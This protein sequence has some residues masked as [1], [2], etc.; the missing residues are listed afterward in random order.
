M[1]T[2]AP[3]HLDERDPANAD[4]HDIREVAD[5]EIDARPGATAL[6]LLMPEDD[7]T[8]FLRLTGAADRNGEATYREV[9]FRRAA[10]TAV[11]AAEGF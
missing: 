10:I 7:W 4:A 5:R 6:V 11:I 3:T 1:T 8:E 9:T 2:P